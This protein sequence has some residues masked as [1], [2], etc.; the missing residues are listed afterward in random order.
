M[1]GRFQKTTHYTLHATACLDQ[2]LIT[3]NSPTVVQC[4]TIT[5]TDCL[6]SR[7]ATPP[8]PAVSLS[9]SLSLCLSMRGRGRLLHALA[10][11]GKTPAW[12]P[13]LSTQLWP[14]DARRTLTHTRHTIDR[15]RGAHSRCLGVKLVHH[16]RLSPTLL[17]L[18]VVFSGPR[19]ARL[20]ALLP[21]FSSRVCIRG[22]SYVQGNNR[23][24]CD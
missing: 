13:V 20:A 8:P 4:S 14:P 15:L 11:R 1:C 3:I 19:R 6:C 18:R 7:V 10:E 24:G 21:I 12:C 16:R 22:R 5:D 23:R 17:S 9:L 2:H